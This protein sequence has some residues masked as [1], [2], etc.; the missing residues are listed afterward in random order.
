VAQRDAPNSPFGSDFPTILNEAGAVVNYKQPYVDQAVFGIEKTFGPRWKLELTY[1]N[2]V[3]RDIAG[4]VDQNLANDWSPIKNLTPFGF[5]SYSPILDQN[6]AKVLVIPVIYVRNDN[7]IAVLQNQMKPGGSGYAGP[8]GYTVAD[9]AH[10]SYHPNI[11]LTTFGTAKRH[12]DQVSL[13]LRTEQE[14]WNG[15]VSVTSSQL[16]GNVAGLTGFSTSDTSFNAGPGVRPNDVINTDG[17]LPNYPAFEAKLWVSGKLWF[18]FQGGAFTTYNL[19]EYFAPTMQITSRFN[20]QPANSTGGGGLPLDPTLF[21]ASNGQTILLEQQGARKYPS[22]ENLDLR[23]E[24]SFGQWTLTAD[25]FNALASAAIIQR[26]L[27]INDQVLR[28][29]TSLFGA[30]RLRVPPR[31]L[32]VGVRFIF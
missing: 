2:R 25:L 27:T 14:N 19:G 16:R 4:L 15:L 17:L 8:P 11:Q 5:I 20:F 32:Q 6:G 7:L 30:P 31:A 21:E 13:T 22:R 1:T 28:D 26:N 23:L 12:L 3:N 10:L 24:R 9:L 29:P 18:G